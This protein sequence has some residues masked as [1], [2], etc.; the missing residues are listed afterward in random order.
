MA[1]M[2]L[3]GFASTMS[4]FERAKEALGG[5]QNEDVV[6]IVGTNV[7]YAAYV[8]LG[9]S[10]TEAQPYLGP[11][12]RKVG[13][14]PEK[15]VGSPDTLAEFIR[16]VALAIEREAKENAPVDTGRLKNSIEATR[17]Q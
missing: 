14:N 8:E 17:V 1:G 7:E 15:Y 13:R 6:Y 3:T 4:A 2:N 12:A 11:A 10:T 16:D 5:P 9:T